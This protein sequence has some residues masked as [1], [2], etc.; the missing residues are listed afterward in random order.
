MPL[1]K[2]LINIGLKRLAKRKAMPKN[3]AVKGVN[4]ITAMGFVYHV[5]KTPFDTLKKMVH[6][7]SKQGIKIYTLGFV[8]EKDLTDYEADELNHYYCLNDIN[9]LRLP[10]QASINHFVSQNFDYL[11]NLDMEGRNELQAI[12]AYSASKIRIGKQFE[13]Y[14]N[15]HDLM[16][17]SVAETPTELLRDIN[18]YIK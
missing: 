4:S 17:R 15:A 2:F 10:K 14:I 5:D 13:N 7:Y 3:E 11:I 12:S 1:L 6:D 9:L 8:E 18:R 16:I